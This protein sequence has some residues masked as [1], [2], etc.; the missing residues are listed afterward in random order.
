MSRTYSNLSALAAA[1]KAN[2]CTVHLHQDDHG[3]NVFSVGNSDIGAREFA[4]FDEAM[5]F[6]AGDK[7]EVMHHD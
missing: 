1:A 7:A 4:S 5:E 3:H 6:V 2:D